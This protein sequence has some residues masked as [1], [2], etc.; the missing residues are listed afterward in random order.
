MN[1]FIIDPIGLDLGDVFENRDG[2]TGFSIPVNQFL[3]REK[4]YLTT[5][6]NDK[7]EGM[8]LRE[9]DDKVELPI[10]E[11]RDLKLR[12]LQLEQIS[13]NNTL[14]DTIHHLRIISIQFDGKEIT[15]D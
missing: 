3:V 1:V 15:I 13:V 5:L 2:N 7:I 6:L 14:T 10:P 12:N 8:Y 11:I 9:I 4:D